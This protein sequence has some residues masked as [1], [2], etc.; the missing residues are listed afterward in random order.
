MLKIMAKKWAK[1][2]K[3]LK[4]KFATT[5]GLNICNYIDIVKMT[6]DVIYN[7]NEQDYGSKLDIEQITQIDNGD[8][9]GTLLYLIPFDTYQPS[10]YE[11]LMTYVDYGSCSGCDTL[12]AIQAYGYS[13]EFLNDRQVK[14]FMQL[15]L[16][17]IQHT[18]R[19][20][21]CGWRKDEDFETIETDKTED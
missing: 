11:Y 14:E 10:E 8:Y 13:E 15:A 2:Q 1:N 9:Q 3:L 17:I 21:N 6:F 5:K 20:Y 16:H 18:I 19:P 7:S 4:Q 12:M